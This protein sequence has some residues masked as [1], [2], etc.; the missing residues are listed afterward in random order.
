MPLDAV[1][2]VQPSEV[3][4]AFLVDVREDD[5]WADGHAP[6]ALHIPLNDIPLRV[7]ELPQD[8][9]VAVICR[10]GSRSAYATAWLVEQGYDARNVD[11]GMLAWASSGLP[12]EV[13]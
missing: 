4:D 2:T 10:V 11:G 7:S 1:P 12:V 5:E 6:G 3:G 13:P 8:R 9:P